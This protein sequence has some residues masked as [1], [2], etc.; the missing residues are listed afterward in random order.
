MNKAAKYFGNGHPTLYYMIAN[1]LE[2]RNR[3]VLV[4]TRQLYCYGCVQP[5]STEYKRVPEYEVTS[6]FQVDES[7]NFLSNK[8]HEHARRKRGTNHDEPHLWYY[9]VQAF[10]MSLHLNLTKNSNL[11]V[12]GLV[13]EKINKNGNKE[14]SDFPHTAFYAGHV[15]SDPNSVVAISNHDGLKGIIKHFGSSFFMQPLP[16]HLARYHGVS[17]GSQPHLIFRRSLDNEK[18][19]CEV[20]ETR[21]KR[22]SSLEK[23][24]SRSFS[25]SR[26]S[27]SAPD[28]H[29]EVLLVA[30]HLYL[31]K[32]SSDKEA[33]DLL[34]TL[35]NID[36][37][38]NHVCISGAS[39]LK[40]RM[41]TH[42]TLCV[43]VGETRIPTFCNASLA[44]GI[45]M[46]QSGST[47]VKHRYGASV[48][49][50]DLGLATALILA[51]ESAHALGVGH[52][53]KE[54]DCPDD[55]FIM[56]TTTA[57]GKDAF[58]WSPC[59]RATL[60]SFLSGSSSSCLDDHP[61]KPVLG[62]RANHNKLPGQ[63]YD[64]DAQCALQFGASYKLCPKMR[65][66]CISLYCTKDGGTS[67]VSSVVQQA[68]GSKCG[69]RQWCIKG[70]CVDDGSP[71]TD[72]GWSQWSSYGQCS[73]SC[74]GG[75]QY[76]TRTCTNPP[77]QNGGMDCE[78]ES[79]GHWRICNPEAC[80][81]GTPTHREAQCTSK[82]SGSAPYELSGRHPCEL[83]CKY[84][85][86]VQPF[87]TVKDGT[88]CRLD[89]KIKDVCIE[90]KCKSV[91]CDNILESGV[92]YDRCKVCNGDS[93]T[94]KKVFGKVLTPC[95]GSCTVLDVPV[96]ATNIT[97]N[98]EVED[99]NFLGVKDGS[100][101]DVY[102]VMY[103]W[104][105]SKHAAGTIVYYYHEKNQDAD[106]VFI[107]GPTNGHLE[108]Y[109]NCI[110]LYC[111]KDGG[112]SC[113]SSV[114]Q[115][116]D[117]SK[118]GDRQWCIK[119]E[120]VDDGS[121][122]TDGG[123]SQWSGYGQC[124]YSCGGG[125]QYRTRT[126]TNPPPQ[127][128][129]MDCKGENVGHWRICN[130]EACPEGTPTHREAQCTSKWS[131]SA[132]YEL[133]GRHPCVLLCKYGSKVQPF[134]N[135]KDGTRCSLDSKIKDVC[136][137]GK[138]KSVGCDNILESG[139]KYDR[140]KVCNGD[141]TTCKKV[142]GKVLTPCK[143]SCTVLDVPFGATNI[144]VNEE[145]ED[146]N[147]LGVKDGSGKDV[148]PVMYTWST[149]KHAAGTIVYYYHEKNQDADRVFIP[150]PTNGHLEVYYKQ[151]VARQPVDFTLNKP[152]GDKHLKPGAAKWVIGEWSVC[153]HS[154]AGGVQT[155]TVECIL[156]SDL[157]Y[158][159]DAVC[160][161]TTQKPSH[162]L[163]CNTQGCPP[164][165]YV[166]GWRPCS[167]TCGKG[168]QTRQVICRQEVTRGKFQT[169]SDS[170]C[171]GNKPSDPVSRDCNKIDCPAEN[172]PGD[173]SACSTSCG[174][175]IKTR[176]KSCQRMKE[177]GVFEPVPDVMCATSTD[178]P[179]QEGC[180][181][182]VKCPGD[183]TYEPLGCFKDG[184]PRALPQLIKNFRKG[185]NWHD[186][187]E[188]VEK[189]ANATAETDPSLEVFSLQFYG[190]C[191]S[192]S[193][194]TKTYDTYGALPY[195][196]DN[197]YYCW[198]G[199]GRKHINFVYKFVD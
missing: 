50:G 45:C 190:E 113:V 141:G 192:G 176:K 31:S 136:I 78:G 61:E 58:R 114:V 135:V 10:G 107:P 69:D 109:S 110:S 24:T 57:K 46:A 175:G 139:V 18:S 177:T 173:W 158:L 29:L 170:E 35:A 37:P 15:T 82:W 49:N 120:C 124:S 43:I 185:I 133:S 20:M 147:F 65:S 165:W 59:S 42:N 62:S 81:E 161:K 163:D 187:S 162:Q 100:G 32:F 143:G 85:L 96:G 130:P 88:R 14:Y 22:S 54:E 127:N 132:P 21:S 126:C 4:Y 171:T 48:S 90:G 181:Q 166:S 67:C 41:L 112:T 194:G 195:G 157:T 121:P 155:R 23:E 149:S 80:P 51:H 70:E 138:C 40:M 89:S 156:Q 129:G 72:G 5:K 55:T 95:K 119:G 91:G 140:C 71:M 56:S 36:L 25:S 47:C 7:G 169:L 122:M 159:N 1:G 183:R 180:N 128:G 3:I 73:Y 77:P 189:C 64:G 34:L 66:N 101:K 86:K 103:T 30:D 52:D 2:F 16:S 151:F 142:F 28:K 108:V 145:V 38:E 199:V 76:R 152:S 148:Y 93:T 84:G 186:M 174:A 26:K 111:T 164:T 117:G 182:D 17:S 6:P 75:A 115:Q 150:G 68:D 97:V 74:G 102:P 106:R 193:N 105:T 92:K 134:G 39:S 27:R 83:L 19:R 13:V 125:V 60:Q 53:G 123:W 178:P 12:P 191:F 196:E 131:R 154:C 153:T 9:Q 11:L 197:F 33:T 184:S 8:L 188:I 104:S 146:W 160:Q 179:L 168:Q 172:I 79:V 116:A 167:R 63:V 94:C 118:C 99:W 137:E 198:E 144:T 98:E 44:S 87:G